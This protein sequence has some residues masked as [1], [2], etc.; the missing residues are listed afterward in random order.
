MVVVMMDDKGRVM[1]PKKVR[2]EIN[3]QPGDALFLHREGGTLQL[4]K[5]ENPFDALAQH[6]EREFRAGRTRSLRDIAA[7]EGV[8]VDE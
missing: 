5:A 1:I 6:A 7:D 2:E 4:A 8:T 3:V